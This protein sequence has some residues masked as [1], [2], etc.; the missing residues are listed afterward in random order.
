[1]PALPGGAEITEKGAVNMTRR[2]TLVE[3]R[4]VAAVGLL[5]LG[6]SVGIGLML[7]QKFA[8]VGLALS[9]VSVAGVIWI[10]NGQFFDVYRALID[11]R[12]YTGTNIKELLIIFSISIV[13]TTLSLSLYFSP[14]N[15]DNPSIR[16][17]LQ[18]STVS[19]V[20]YSNSATSVFNIE[21]KNVGNLT[22]TKAITRAGGMLSDHIL[23]EDK[24]R[25][26]M[27][28]LIADIQRF[29]QVNRHSEIQQ[30]QSAVI[31]I[32]DLKKGDRTALEVTDDELSKINHAHPVDAQGHHI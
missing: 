10:Y 24:E 13:V 25:A 5:A 32:P 28:K 4:V 7:A 19:P 23:S 29:Q 17:R 12:A 8:L 20:K 30:G 16:S 21:I 11:K 26:E 31:T 6:S 2:H 27:E 22:A 9:L 14:P 18:F 15:T 3:P 1:M